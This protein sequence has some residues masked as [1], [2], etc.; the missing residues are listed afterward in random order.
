MR[1]K[2]ARHSHHRASL[3]M[4]RRGCPSYITI[5]RYTLLRPL[6]SPR[7]YPAPPIASLSLRFAVAMRRQSDPN[8]LGT[9]GKTP[10]RYR[11]VRTRSVV[12]VSSR[13]SAASASASASAAPATARPLSV[14][15]RPP[16]VN[17]NRPQ[18]RV[19]FAN[20]ELRVAWEK[21]AGQRLEILEDFS[22]YSFTPAFDRQGFRYKR[23][24]AHGD[25]QSDSGF[26]KGNVL[27]YTCKEVTKIVHDV[28][29][30]RPY[31]LRYRSSTCLL[32]ILTDFWL[33]DLKCA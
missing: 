31:L 13:R 24:S 1:P 22:S 33:V 30:V 3:Q 29:G 14:F 9:S 17:A 19:T 15:A 16:Q 11:E 5:I 26:M 4:S 27:G 10:S 23:Y 18:R 12:S 7:R 20:T 21:R 25:I 28:Y 8:L 32:D 6:I 2:Q